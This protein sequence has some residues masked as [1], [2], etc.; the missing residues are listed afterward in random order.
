VHVDLGLIL[1]FHY[2]VSLG[3]YFYMTYKRH[4]GGNRCHMS[5]IVPTPTSALVILN[6]ASL[7]VYKCML[8]VQQS[9]VMITALVTRDFW[10]QENL[11]DCRN[12]LDYDLRT[13]ALSKFT[14]K[15]YKPLVLGF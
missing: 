5:H 12:V 2:F 13:I 1:D 3:K 9:L 11:M 4:K 10:I 14:R 7:Q 8:N 15:A 6:F